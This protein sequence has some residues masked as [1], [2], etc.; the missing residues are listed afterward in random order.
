MRCEHCPVEVGKTCLG[1]TNPEAFPHFCRWATSPE[2]REREM[3]V[4][5]SAV[6]YAPPERVEPAPAATGPGLLTR[7]V[8][9]G[10]AIVSHVAAGR[11]EADE[12]TASA[13]LAICL[14]C[15]HLDARA[16]TCNL[17][18]CALFVKTY[19]LDQHCPI[20]KW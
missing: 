8:N 11:P 17:C 5:R 19:W 7:A 1:D 15:E 20:E 13:R 3:V 2:P 10:K 4:L 9:F 16:M 6:G 12:P 14:G 18:G